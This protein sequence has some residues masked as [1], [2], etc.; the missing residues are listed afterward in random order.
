MQLHPGNPP[1]TSGA[2][3]DFTEL[4]FTF[5]NSNTLL[6]AAVQNLS[7]TLL[8]LDLSTG[9]W[10]DDVQL[11]ASLGGSPVFLQGGDFTIVNPLFVTS[12]VGVD[13]DQFTATDGPIDSTST[14]GNVEIN[15]SQLV[16]TLVIRYTGAAGIEAQ[17]IGISG[18][19]GCIF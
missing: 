14:D 4:T 18:F 19:S 2:D 12:S 16:D 7:F 10:L 3:G 1:G 8:D 17:Q 15:Y 6:P 9:A 13:Y 5:V 11:Y